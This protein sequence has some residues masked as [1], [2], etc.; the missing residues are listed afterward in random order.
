[1]DGHGQQRQLYEAAKD[2]NLTEVNYL[3]D[4]GVKPIYQDE[5]S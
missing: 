5:V 3:L 4:N 1:M 2:G